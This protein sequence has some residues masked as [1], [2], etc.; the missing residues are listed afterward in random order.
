MVEYKGIGENGMCDRCGRN[1]M[2]TYHF[3]I[4]GEHIVLGSS[5]ASKTSEF[6]TV[7]TIKKFVDT[8]NEIKSTERSLKISKEWFPL[9]F[10]S[11]AA[12]KESKKNSESNISRLSKKLVELKKELVII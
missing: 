1:L 7:K 5:C 4:D 8:E 2:T 6:L 12:N 11:D 9:S 10:L 3:I